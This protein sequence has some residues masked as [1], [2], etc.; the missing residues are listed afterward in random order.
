LFF[1]NKKIFAV[2][3]IFLLAGY[4]LFNF[5]TE[6]FNGYAQIEGETAVVSGEITDSYYTDS[7]G[8]MLLENTEIKTEGTSLYGEKVFIYVYGNDKLPEQGRCIFSAKVNTNKIFESGKINSYS[9]RNKIHYNF[10]VNEGNFVVTEGNPS[11]FLKV[12][13]HIKSILYTYLR[14]ENAGLCYALVTGDSLI[15]DND[16]KQAFSNTGIAH[17]FSVSGLHI[18]VLSVCIIYLLNK[19]KV[20]KLYQIFITFFFLLFYAGICD[21]TP[22]VL[23]ALVMTTV[24]LI[25]K[26][27]GIKYDS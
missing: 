8:Y 1:K 25:S 19:L 2:L 16:L 26:A 27:I 10:F 3:F 21:F 18:G 20:K 17:I 15:M 5:A 23:R 6:R 9:Y 4:L 12:K 24:Y 14:Q 7:G 11:I 13:K 22:S